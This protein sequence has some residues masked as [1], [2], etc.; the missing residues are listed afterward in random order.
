MTVSAF[1]LIDGLFLKMSRFDLKDDGSVLD[2]ISVFENNGFLLVL[3][4]MIGFVNFVVLYR[5]ND[6]LEVVA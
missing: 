3:R 6:S 2:M 5:K 1:L 4:G